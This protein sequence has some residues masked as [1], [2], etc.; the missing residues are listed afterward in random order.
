MCSVHRRDLITLLG[1]A[2]AVLPIKVG[3]QVERIWRM[4]VLLFSTQDRITIKPFIDELQARGYVDG[5]TVKIEYRDAGGNYE[6]LPE[7]AA[8]LV[9]LGPDVLFAF[10]GELAPVMKK[11]TTTIPTVV[12]VSN[13]P[14]A[15]GIVAS[16]ARPG[17]NITGLTFIY[18]QL[19]G[20]AIE[21]LRE[22]VPSV[23]RV[24]VLWNPNHADPEFRE[25]QRGAQALRI[26]IQSLEV[27]EPRDFDGA[28]QALVR[29]QPEALIVFGSRLMQLH[30]RRIGDFVEKN[31]L[32]LVGNPSWLSEIGGLLT[33]GAN[34][35]D[36][37]RRAASYV[38]KILKGARPADL[39]MQQPTAFELIVNLKAAKALNLSIPPQLLAR[40]DEVIE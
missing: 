6:R 20:K 3:A 16:L 40:A 9:G 4:G 37:M 18:D 31:K 22:V 14:V 1:G 39:P 5:K 10:S 38:E 36:L 13:D 24:A 21:L 19:A 8:E 32:V 27:R 15:S 17:G 35:A 30:R 29:Q 2:A 11:A 34:V 12:V 26:E 28:F 7:L 25:T 33:Y 23:S